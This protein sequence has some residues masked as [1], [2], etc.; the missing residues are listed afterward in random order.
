MKLEARSKNSRVGP[1]VWVARRVII[2]LKVGVSVLL[3]NYL[4][5]SS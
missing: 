2:L 3:I 1:W 5:Y 4:C